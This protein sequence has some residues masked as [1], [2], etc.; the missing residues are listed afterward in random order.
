MELIENTNSDMSSLLE[1][2][3]DGW[4]D[5][6]AR[7]P[8][9]IKTSDEYCDERSIDRLDLVKSIRRAMTSRS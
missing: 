3:A 8:V 1:I 9:Q 4:G 7:T 6:R 5:V 2:G